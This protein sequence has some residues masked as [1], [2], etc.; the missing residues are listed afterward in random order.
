MRRFL[1][2]MPFGGDRYL[3][4]D[5]KLVEERCLESEG[6]EGAPNRECGGAGVQRQYGTE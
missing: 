5:L 1:T 6:A 2:E 4:G 3:L